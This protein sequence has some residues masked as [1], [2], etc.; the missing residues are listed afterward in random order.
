MKLSTKIALGVVGTFGTISILSMTPQ[1]PDLKLKGY[2]QTAVKK[3]IAKKNI[4]SGSTG[5]TYSGGGSSY[6]K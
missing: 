4:R 3:I 1:R 6:G 2:K 5:R